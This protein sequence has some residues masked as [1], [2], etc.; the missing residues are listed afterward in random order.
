[1]NVQVVYHGSLS[2]FHLL[3]PQSRVQCDSN[4]DK[5]NLPKEQISSDWDA[6]FNTGK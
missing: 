3:Q 1:M 6:S 2:T 4:T 5:F